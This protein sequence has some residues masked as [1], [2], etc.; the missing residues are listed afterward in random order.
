MDKEYWREYFYEHCGDNYEAARY[1]AEPSTYSEEI[2][3][4]DWS[5]INELCDNEQ[6]RP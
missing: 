6:S 5:V 3:D 2:S 1:E 4:D